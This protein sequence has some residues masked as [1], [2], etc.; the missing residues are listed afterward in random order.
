MHR[1]DS[2][3]AER[4]D[5]FWNRRQGNAVLRAIS[6]LLF[7]FGRAERFVPDVYVDDGD[8]LSAYGL[9]ARVLHLPGHSS[10]SIGI[11]TARGDLFCG[12]LVENT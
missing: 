5:M 10:G 8:E 9:S 2:G 3:M 6:P 11:L 1:G 12:D 4:G 7:G